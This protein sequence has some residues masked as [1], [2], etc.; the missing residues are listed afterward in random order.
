MTEH[1]FVDGDIIYILDILVVEW[2]G[3]DIEMVHVLFQT[4]DLFDEDQV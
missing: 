2:S 1:Y 3:G 4:R